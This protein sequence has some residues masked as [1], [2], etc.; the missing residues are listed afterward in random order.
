MTSDPKDLIQV[1]KLKLKDQHKHISPQVYFPREKGP[2]FLQI[3]R[4]GSKREKIKK[5]SSN[6][7]PSNCSYKPSSNNKS[8]L[9]EP[10][11]FF[12]IYLSIGT[13]TSINQSS[14]RYVLF[15]FPNGKNMCVPSNVLLAKNLL[16]IDVSSLSKATKRMK[17]VKTHVNR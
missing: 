2:N 5:V 9:A 14:Q 7:T 6:R 4:G 1:L 12:F 13:N 8:T 11:P 3:F 10:P 16:V 15:P 17:V